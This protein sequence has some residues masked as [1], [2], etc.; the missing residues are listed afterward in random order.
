MNKIKKREEKQ[1]KRTESK[2]KK[3]MC[4]KDLLMMIEQ[5]I[6]IPQCKCIIFY[7][8]NKNKN[9]KTKRKRKRNKFKSKT[10]EKK[11]KEKNC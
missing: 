4:K 5:V 10:K 8:K 6:Q 1:T 2:F 9:L 3:N 11:R 7:D